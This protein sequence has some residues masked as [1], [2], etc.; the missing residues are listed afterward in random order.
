M[1]GDLEKDLRAALRREEPPDGFAE[2]VLA[3][4]SAP[5]RTNGRALPWW[6]FA[7]AAAAACLTLTVGISE[8]REQR[9]ERARGEAAKQELLEAMRITGSKLRVAQERVRRFHAQ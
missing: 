9:Q 4:T 7:A 1:S 6:S 5:R 2:R 3:R 8:Y